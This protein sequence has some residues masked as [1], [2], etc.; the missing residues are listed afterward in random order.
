MVKQQGVSMV[1]VSNDWRE[2]LKIDAWNRNP[3][4]PRIIT[5]ANAEN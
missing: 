3:D 5:P 2:A 4:A 1:P